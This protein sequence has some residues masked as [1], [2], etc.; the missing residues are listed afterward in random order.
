MAAKAR[1]RGRRNCRAGRHE[2][3]R[4][5]CRIAAID[6]LRGIITMEPDPDAP[7]ECAWCRTTDMG[8]LA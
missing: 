5:G 1:R 8:E 4:M 2:Y 6:Q 7:M 3:T